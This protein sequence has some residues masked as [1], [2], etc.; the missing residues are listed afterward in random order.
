MSVRPSTPPVKRPYD[1]PRRVAQ[2]RVTRRRITEAAATLFAERGFVA[3]SFDAIASAAG[4]GRATVF[5]N[6]P[7]KAALLKAAYDVTLVGDDDPVPLRD[8]PRSR[9]V[10]AE[11]DAHRYLAGYA[12]IVADIARRLAPIYVAIRAA[13]PADPEADAVWRALNEERRFGAATVVRQAGEK[14]HLRAGLDP[15]HAADAVWAFTDSGLYY[16]LVRE[17]G[18]THDEYEAW[19][20]AKLQAELL[21]PIGRERR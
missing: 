1:A 18:W 10:M 13:A 14:G 16:A 2:A 12:G 4:V 15:A 7:T 17:R 8:R 6:F 5:A 19:L 11:P 9:A 21:R 3:T 20:A